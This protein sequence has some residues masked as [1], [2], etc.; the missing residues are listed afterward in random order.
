MLADLLQLDGQYLLA[1]SHYRALLKRYQSAA[2]LEPI[3]LRLAQVQYR[4]KHW[5]Q[6]ENSIKNQQR[7][8]R[9]AALPTKSAPLSLLLAAQLAQQHWSHAIETSLTLRQLEP[10]NSR[11][12]YQLVN[13]YLKTEQYQRALVTLQQADRAQIALADQQLQLMAQLY[14]Q[15]GVPNRAAETYQRLSGLHLSAGLLA[16]QASFWLAANEWDRAAQSWSQAAQIDKRYHWQ[17]AQ[18]RLQ[19]SAYQDA[20]ASLEI[21]ISTADSAAEKARILILKAQALN[22]LGEQRAALVAITKAHQIAPSDETRGWIN[23]LEAY[24]NHD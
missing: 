21:L 11:W 17:L 23:Y 9:E 2:D 18:L 8:M 3:W 12:W 20:L 15:L 22:E 10:D 14:A 24:S 7:Q 1:E 13:L 5:S 19:Q 4:L 16:Q 6:V